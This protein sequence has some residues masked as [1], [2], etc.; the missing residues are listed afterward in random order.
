M[1][2]T[3]YT[4]ASLTTDVVGKCATHIDPDMWF[5]EFTSGLIT[6]NRARAMAHNVNDA[7]ELCNSCPIKVECLKAGMLEE[8]II[9]GIWG[10]KTA[11][12]RILSTGRVRSDYPAQSEKGKAIDFYERIK[13]WLG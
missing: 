13:P 10:G 9:Y 2:L 6:E 8:N 5:P 4:M 11:G 3:D 12:E 1:T 7:V